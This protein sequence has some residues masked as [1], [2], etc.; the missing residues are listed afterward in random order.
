MNSRRCLDVLRL[1]ALAACCAAVASA[2]PQAVG[3]AAPFFAP[4]PVV[5]PG[6]NPGVVIIALSPSAAI[7]GGPSFTLTVTGSGFA[8]NSVVQWNGAALTTDFGSTSQLSAL[9]AASLIDSP[10]DATITVTSGGMTSNGAIFTV[11]G[12][13]ESWRPIFDSEAVTLGQVNPLFP[14]SIVSDWQT[15][16]AFA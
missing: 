10:A 8:A 5:P 2:Q 4:I 9:V 16:V 7:A 13:A 11:F 14:D 3:G 12:P 6:T 15:G 1:L